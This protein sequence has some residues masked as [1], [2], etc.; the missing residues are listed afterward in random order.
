MTDRHQLSIGDVIEWAR[1]KRKWSQ[2][3]LARRAGVAHQ[4]VSRWEQGDRPRFPDSVRR[5]A[6]VLDL[7][8]E[9]LLEAPGGRLTKW[10][11]PE[12]EMPTT[13]DQCVDGPRPCPWYA[14]RYHLGTFSRYGSVAVR[15]DPNDIDTTPLE[16]CALDLAARGGMTL[17]EVGEAVGHTRERVRQLQVGAIRRVATLA[18][19]LADYFGRLAKEAD[20]LL[21]KRVVFRYVGEDTD[22]RSPFAPHQVRSKAMADCHK[23]QTPLARVVATTVNHDNYYGVQLADGWHLVKSMRGAKTRV[24][25]EAGCDECYGEEAD[26][27]AA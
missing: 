18:P 27:G 16:T 20:M 4:T 26:R 15:I 12:P 21:H 10:T 23:C 14:C 2:R 22:F 19:D 24:A 25:K 6:T 8:A 11:Q 13:R 9:R 7:N 17:T 1:R 3:E 5:V